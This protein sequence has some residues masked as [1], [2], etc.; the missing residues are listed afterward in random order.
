MV[1]NSSYLDIQFQQ[2]EKR[3]RH[4]Y[5]S[6]RREQELQDK[7]HRRWGHWQEDPI[8]NSSA[9]CDRG[10]AYDGFFEDAIK[11]PEIAGYLCEWGLK[12]LVRLHADK[13]CTEKRGEPRDM[14]RK[15]MHMEWIYILTVIS[16]TRRACIRQAVGH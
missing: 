12:L 10:G 15:A 11:E 1:W 14:I 6:M 13:D 7:C 3:R 9:E 5:R 2:R 8:S 16:T 4:V